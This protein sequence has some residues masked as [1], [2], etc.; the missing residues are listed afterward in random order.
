MRISEEGVTLVKEFEGFR[1]APYRDAVG[2][3]TIGYGETKGVGPDTHS[4]TQKEASDLLRRRLDADYGSH[5]TNLGVELAQNQFDAIT[6]F[7]YNVGP[8]GISRDTG[9]GRALRAKNWSVA[10]DELLKWDKAGGR[11]LAGLTRRR[12]AERALFL[13][14][15]SFARELEVY[16]ETEIRWIREYDKLVREKRDPD[17][18]QVLRRVMAHQRKR[19]WHAAQKTGWDKG[20]RRD[21]Y[22]SLMSRTT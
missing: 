7:V 19:I 6:S 21:R 5:V 9:I 8:G 12:R 11:A 20:N 10:A 15:P 18:R 17:R 16:A 22:N 2:V 1:S 3:W 14:Q 13:R 4:I